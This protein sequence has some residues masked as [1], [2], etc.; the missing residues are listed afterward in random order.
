MTRSL[1]IFTPPH[2]PLF[3]DSVVPLETNVRISKQYTFAPAGVLIPAERIKIYAVE[4]K[5][6]TDVRINGNRDHTYIH[7]M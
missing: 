1:H 4:A 6:A 7:T 2:C 3:F 5:V